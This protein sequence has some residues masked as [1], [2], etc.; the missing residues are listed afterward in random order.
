MPT[1]GGEQRAAKLKDALAGIIPD[2]VLVRFSTVME[3]PKLSFEVNR[4]FAADM[5]AAVSPAVRRVL[6][7]DGPAAALDRDL[8]GRA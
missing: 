8:G 4:R 2:G 1:T 5:M 3:G 6:I 7:G